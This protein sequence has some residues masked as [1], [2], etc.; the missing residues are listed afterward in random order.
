[1]EDNKA[2][3]A[4]SN[5]AQL[6][7]IRHSASHVMATAVLQI[8]P[9]ARLAIGPPIDNG[10]YY[11]FELPRP[12]TPDDLE[13]IEA[14]VLRDLRRSPPTVGI[15]ADGAVH[16][17]LG[18]RAYMRSCELRERISHHHRTRICDGTRRPAFGL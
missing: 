17:T 14:A 2:L 1:M 3:E 10:F 13:E 5:A 7:K 18:W 15:A 6:W 4:P 16:R 11:D 8:F 12:L 9:D